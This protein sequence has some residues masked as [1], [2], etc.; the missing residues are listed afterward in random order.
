MT[1]GWPTMPACS[2]KTLFIM[3]GMP[4]AGPANPKMTPGWPRV[5]ACVPT[6][7]LVMFSAANAGPTNPKIAPRWPTDTFIFMFNVSNAAPASQRR[8]PPPCLD[9]QL[10]IM[11]GVKVQK[12]PSS[13][14]MGGYVEARGGVHKVSSSGPTLAGV[15]AG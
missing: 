6:R 1:L 7:L 9:P 14:A 11:E 10:R 5:Q 2:P 12:K 13:T 8:A 15:L 3:F 4:N